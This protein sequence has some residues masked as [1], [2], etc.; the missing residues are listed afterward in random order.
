MPI[1]N[2]IRD[3]KILILPIDVVNEQRKDE[4][5]VWA[6]RY[7]YFCNS[8]SQSSSEFIFCLSRFDPE[9]GDN[10]QYKNVPKEISDAIAKAIELK[11]KRK[12]YEM[13]L[14]YFEEPEE[15]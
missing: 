12:D 4:L 8:D 3:C 5:T 9:V 13:V 10:W 11:N 6:E 15:E 7:C 14:I 1:N 2:F